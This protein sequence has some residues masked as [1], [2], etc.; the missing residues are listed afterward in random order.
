MLQNEGLQFWPMPMARF[1]QNPYGANQ[2]RI[3]FAP[4]RRHFVYGEWKDGQRKGKWIRKYPE[5]SAR[6]VWILERWRSAFDYMHTDPKEWNKVA[7]NFVDPE[8]EYDICHEFFSSQPSEANMGKLITWIETRHRASENAVAVRDEYEREEKASQDKLKE[9]IR[10][11]LPAFGNAP[12][13]GFGGGSGTKTHKDFKLSASDVKLPGGR[14][15]PGPGQYTFNPRRSRKIPV[16]VQVQQV[17]LEG[18]R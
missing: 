10:E 11:L 9:K 4:S 5:E 1:G 8:G 3:V 13:S 14:A 15:M 2:Y 16:K 17:A 18:A 6:K 7:P 12:V